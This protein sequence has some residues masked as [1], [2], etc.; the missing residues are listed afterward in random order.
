MTPI[1]GWGLDPYGTGPYGSSTAGVGIHVVSALAISTNEVQVTLSGNARHLS[2]NG[3]GDALNPA[4]W[5]VTRVDTAA[6]LPVVAVRPVTPAIYV[7]TTI[8]PFGP[9]TSLHTVLTNTL[10]DAGGSTLV[11]PRTASFYGVIDA[12]LNE[13]LLMG[14]SRSIAVDIDNPQTPNATPDTSG[15][16][17]VINSSGDYDSVQGADLVRKLIIRRLSTRPGEFF[18][19]PT[20]GLDL[21][22]K[23]PIHSADLVQLKAQIDAQVRREPEVQDVSATLVATSDGVVTATIKA[24]LK[25]GLPVTATVPLNAVVAL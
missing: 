4:T 3:A 20:Y 23:E 5:A 2:P 10:V 17:L 21:Q 25:T 6:N 13:N 9:C 18:H 22:V 1:L 16:T 19:L 12:S 7:L 14:K 15:G 24:R 8:D 11:P